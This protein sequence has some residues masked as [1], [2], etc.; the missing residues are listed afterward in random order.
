MRRWSLA[1][2][3]A[4][5]ACDVPEPPGTRGVTDVDLC[6]TSLVVVESD[7]ESTNVALVAMD[8]RVLTGSVASSAMGL[9]RDVVL[10]SEASGGSVVVLI[11]RMP[12][13]RIVWVDPTTARV[14]SDRSVAT[15]FPSNPRD[16]VAIAPDK[17]YVT[18]YEQN[19]APSTQP[20]DRG[21][22]VLVLD[23][24]RREIVGSI[25]MRPAVADAPGA[26]PRPDRIAVRGDRAFVLLGTLATDFDATFPSR[27]AE[28]DTRSDRIVSVLPLTGFTQC[29]GIEG[30]PFGP[31]LVVNCLGTFEATGSSALSGSGIVVVDVSGSPVVSA[32]FPA[33][34]LGS[35]P[36][37]FESAWAGP[38][39]ILVQ[40]FGHFADSAT[41]A[42]DDIVYRLDIRTGEHEA[43][44]SS[45]AEAFSLGG[46]ACEPSCGAC[47][48]ADAGRGGVVHR[49]DVDEAGV[50]S[51]ARA[52]EV[53]RAIGLPPRELGKVR[54]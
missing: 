35:N 9:G 23:P 21:S 44:L 48:V 1:A 4:L 39:A 20:F 53:E 24:E 38:D 36:V 41:A 12:E 42:A 33:A 18:R 6:P 5:C 19:L 50:V 11:D 43:A 51:G 25:D 27:V 2:A 30:S 54:L 16:Y 8:G 3:L 28:I 32:S 37:G 40:T 46:I 52:I 49:F 15:G 10:P 17:A 34:D 26:L 29:A 45:D 22:D 14:I 31:E 47:F 13:A 7:Y